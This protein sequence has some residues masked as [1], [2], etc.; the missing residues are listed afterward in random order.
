[1]SGS[2]PLFF[3]PSQQ[4]Y[5][6]L[7]A[8]TL[9]FTEN[10]AICLETL[11]KAKLGGLLL[12]NSIIKLSPS[13]HSAFHYYLVK[14][15]LFTNVDFSLKSFTGEIFLFI[16]IFLLNTLF[17]NTHRSVFLK[18]TGFFYILTNLLLIPFLYSLKQNSN[19]PQIVPVLLYTGI[20][21]LFFEIFTL[22]IV[23]I[24]LEICPENLEGF[25]MSLIFFMNNFSKNIGGFLG[26][27]I[28]YALSIKSAELMHLS[29]LIFI[30]FSVSFFGFCILLISFVPDK[31]KN[32][33]DGEEIQAIENSHLAHVKSRHSI[34]VLE[35]QLE[36]KKRQGKW[37]SLK[38]EAIFESKNGKRFQSLNMH[39]NEIIVPNFEN[40]SGEID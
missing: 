19:M 26:T 31:I 21:A 29:W 36:T 13:F 17:K 16:G 30:N 27:V 18:F 20:H 28:I 8:S 9:N 24:F 3:S 10:L 35:D 23:S 38:P 11:K 32:D 5:V 37:G 14:S 33:R 15:L 22:P 1:L 39:A 6:F 34:F 7:K 12:S 25:F 4:F 2:L 40:E